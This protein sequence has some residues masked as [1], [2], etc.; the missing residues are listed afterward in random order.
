MSASGAAYANTVDSK[1]AESND[2]VNKLLNVENIQE[3]EK[4]VDKDAKN[5]S[6]ELIYDSKKSIDN[7][8]KLSSLQEEAEL[9]EAQIK[10]TEKQNIL[11]EKQEASKLKAEIEKNKKLTEE[12]S[13][14]NALISELEDQNDNLKS[15]LSSSEQRVYALEQAV[16]KKEAGEDFFAKVVV[17]RVYGINNNLK[18]DLVYDN[19]IIT[20]KEG[21]EIANG[22]ILTK[23]NEDNIVV[24]KGT[25]TKTIFISV[26][27]KE[28]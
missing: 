17:N 22:L 11:K 25:T 28:N 7:S 5:R 8:N 12:I 21:Q 15:S 3:I 6:S 26:Y 2:V 27:D 14:L 23:V 1:N 24:K 19:N 20:R 4:N 9:L 10:V 13:Q 16:K 18:A